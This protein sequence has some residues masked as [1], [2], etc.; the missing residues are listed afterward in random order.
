M[1]RVLC[2]ISLFLLVESYE[3]KFCINC[4]HFIKQ[5]KYSSPEYGKC[6]KYPRDITDTKYLV[7]GIKDMSNYFF[8][9]TARGTGMCGPDGK[10]Y[11]SK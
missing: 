3:Q 1:F 2:I 10:D 9:T 8:C 7:T 4:K 6:L 11:E 5:S